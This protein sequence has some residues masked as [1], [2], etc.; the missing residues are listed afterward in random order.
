MSDD[1]NRIIFGIDLDLGD[2]SKSID[3]MIAGFKKAQDQGT[4]T[5]AQ[6]EKMQTAMDGATASAN[7][8]REA[9][10]KSIAFS[11]NDGKITQHLSTIQAGVQ[12]MTDTVNKGVAGAKA[13][14]SELQAQQ[15][16]Y[17]ANLLNMLPLLME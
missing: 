7:N 5:G 13:K 6:L 3:G 2:F 10:G 12:T 9:T 17:K 16:A 11:L 14:L 8:L 1:L 15:V 4:L